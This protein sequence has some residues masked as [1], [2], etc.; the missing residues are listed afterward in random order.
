MI[1]YYSGN[2]DTWK[3]TPE[4]LFSTSACIML[5]YE[6]YH[7][8]DDLDKRFQLVKDGRKKPKKKKK[9]KK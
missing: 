6:N 2:G 9:R 8:R 7:S 1:I 5:T 4:C 3:F